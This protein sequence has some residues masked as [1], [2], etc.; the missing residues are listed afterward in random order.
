MKLLLVR[1]GI[2][3]DREEFEQTGAPDEQRPLTK[4]GRK[5]MKGA[6]IGLAELIERPDL[7]ATSPLTRAVETAE[8]VAKVY[9]GMSPTTVEALDPLQPF[10]SFLEWLKRA[11]D[12][13]TVIAVGHEPH[14]SGLAA[15]LSAGSEKPFFELKKGGVCL[16]E[17]EGAIERGSAQLRWLLTPGQLRAVRS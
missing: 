7:V 16:L 1:H 14:L 9:K 11:D 4:D 5:K 10:E 17:F 3:E 8:I 15:W 6:A 12:A 2:A 13:D